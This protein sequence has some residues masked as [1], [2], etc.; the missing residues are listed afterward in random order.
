MLYAALKGQLRQYLNHVRYGDVLLTETFTSY[1]T[2]GPL[3]FY[4]QK[5]KEELE[6]LRTHL[7]FINLNSG[8]F[9]QVIE[10]F[11]N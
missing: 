2:E 11:L 7:V 1:L 10:D 5:M 3:A 6:V 4:R 9:D 8:K